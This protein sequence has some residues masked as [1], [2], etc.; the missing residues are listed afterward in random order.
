MAPSTL[1]TLSSGSVIRSGSVNR[2]DSVIR[3]ECLKE[4]CSKP[5]FMNH[6]TS[7]FLLFCCGFTFLGLTNLF[8]SQAHGLEQGSDTCPP[9]Y[10][11]LKATVMSQG[12][13]PSAPLT[14]A[15]IAAI[16]C[17]AL[18]ALLKEEGCVGGPSGGPAIEDKE[19]LYVDVAALLPVI[20]SE[21]NDV[22]VVDAE[23]MFLTT[24]GVNTFG[25]GVPKNLV[26]VLQNP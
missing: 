5:S 6:T 9:F 22:T 1:R 4:Q 7:R 14:P 12:G 16:I 18:Y 2:K 26:P 11:N 13:N 19:V 24:A 23:G 17:P 8:I 15:S 21:S 20:T 10:Q 25:V 3:S